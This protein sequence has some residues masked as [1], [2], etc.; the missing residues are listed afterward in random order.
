MFLLL[1]TLPMTN[2]WANDTCHLLLLKPNTVAQHTLPGKPETKGTQ[3]C[4]RE[5]EQSSTLCS[6]TVTEFSDSQTR[7]HQ[8]HIDLNGNSSSQL[9]PWRNFKQNRKKADHVK[10]FPEL[11]CVFNT[12][13][14]LSCWQRRKLDKQVVFC[15]LYL[16]F[17]GAQFCPFVC[18]SDLTNVCCGL[19]CITWSTQKPN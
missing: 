5:S 7:T 6:R 12:W 2:S 8:D 15:L 19:M 4:D 11:L 9:K 1:F 14:N 16:L 18:I 10:Y 13:H 17:L 3:I